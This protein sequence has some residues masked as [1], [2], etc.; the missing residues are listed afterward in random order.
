MAEKFRTIKV[1]NKKKLNYIRM[2]EILFQTQE[3]VEFSGL[4]KA[5]NTAVNCA[6][7]LKRKGYATIQKIET[8]IVQEETLKSAKILIVM[9]R[10]PDFLSR[11][12]LENNN[13]N[14]QSGT[15]QP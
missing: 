7:Y 2:A 15:S 6:E 13:K 9:K 10:T 12:P 1:G 11:K 5:I 8:S 3:E 14:E 4:G